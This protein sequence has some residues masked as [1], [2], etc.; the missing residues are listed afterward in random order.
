MI[1]DKIRQDIKNAMKSGNK[2]TVS[3]LRL[4]D[5]E[6]QGD[7]IKLKQDINDELVISV[8]V[9]GIKQRSNVLELF[10]KENRQDLVDSY[11]TQIKVYQSYLPEPFTT[12]Q[13]LTIIDQIIAENGKTNKFEFYMKKVM[14][15]VKGRA[16]AK[17]VD[18]LIKSRLG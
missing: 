18:Q 12:D 11:N 2:D 1:Y 14:S 4:L 16:D 17:V 10:T 5:S 9:R 7:A 15:Q 13:I 8:I 3:C 6:I